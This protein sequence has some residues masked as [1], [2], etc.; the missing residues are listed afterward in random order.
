MKTSEL[1]DHHRKWIRRIVAS[2]R[3]T[4][5]RVF[6]SVLRGEDV[7]ESDLDILVDTTSESSIFDI[8]ELHYRLRGLLGVSVEV[9]TPDSL[10]VRLRL[11]V[12]AEARPV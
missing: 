9:V 8:G 2:C 11:R 4:N 6:G 3:A 5:P 1:L 7:E 12:V 10:H